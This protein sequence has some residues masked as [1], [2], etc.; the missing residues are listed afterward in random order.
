MLE[1]IRSELEEAG[2]A[3]VGARG[4]QA[5]RGQQRGGDQLEASS[6]CGAKLNTGF[7]MGPEPFIKLPGRL[8][9]LLG[10]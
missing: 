6:A 9:E 3:R 5:P 7:T 8:A 1:R 10:L 2:D 4:H